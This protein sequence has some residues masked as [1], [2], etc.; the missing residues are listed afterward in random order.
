[1]WVTEQHR[2]WLAHLEQ[3][4]LKPRAYALAVTLAALT[5]DLQGWTMHTYA[6]LASVVG[7]RN[8]RISIPNGH[9]MLGRAGLE[10]EQAGLVERR[11]QINR[12]GHQ[13]GDETPYLWRFLTGATGA[14]PAWPDAATSTI[15]FALGWGVALGPTATALRLHLDSAADASGTLR[16]TV[17]ELVRISGMSDKTAEKHVR[18]QARHGAG[19]EVSIAT[20]SRARTFAIKLAVP[21]LSARPGRMPAPLRLPAGIDGG[22]PEVETPIAAYPGTRPYTLAELTELLEDLPDGDLLREVIANCE[23][24]RGGRYTPTEQVSEYLAPLLQLWQGVV[25]VHCSEFIAATI[26]PAMLALSKKE[27]I[28]HPNLYIETICRRELTIGPSIDIFAPAA[29]AMP[30]SRREVQPPS[31]GGRM[32][33]V[34]SIEAARSRRYDDDYS[35]DDRYDLDSPLY[36]IPDDAFLR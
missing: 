15:A 14:L 3:L 13:Y 27:L 9:N 34:L 1:M 35:D 21:R 25:G 17:A 18:A 22:V 32:I 30:T 31:A 33:P 6:D 24:H 4:H 16:L 29:A 12:H 7:S 11:R 20:P 5:P 23:T 36:D 28:A 8:E 26:V 19:V 10:L 2:H